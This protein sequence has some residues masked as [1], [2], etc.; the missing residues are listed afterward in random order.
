MASASSWCQRQQPSVDKKWKFWILN[1]KGINYLREKLII[2]IDN[3][4][5]TV[6]G[7]LRAFHWD[8]YVCVRSQ[9]SVISSISC[10]IFC[11]HLIQW[12]IYSVEWVDLS[13]GPK[14]PG[15]RR[16]PLAGENFSGVNS[17]NVPILWGKKYKSGFHQWQAKNRQTDSNNILKVKKQ[18]TQVKSHF[19][20]TFGGQ[21]SRL[22]RRGWLRRLPNCPAIRDFDWNFKFSFL[23]YPFWQPYQPLKWTKTC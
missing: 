7:L 15:A 4:Y 19:L 11:L 2:S 16:G 1:L 12:R 5:V 6:S 13:T 10:R 20:C 23:C 17:V 21:K 18:R 9:I 3:G 22:A 8:V 14:G